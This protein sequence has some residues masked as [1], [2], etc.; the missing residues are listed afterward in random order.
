MQVDSATLENGATSRG[1]GPLLLDGVVDLLSQEIAG[2]HCRKLAIALVD[3]DCEIPFTPAID[4]DIIW[5]LRGGR[6]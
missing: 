3:P 5:S 6:W 4:G 1:V 2:I